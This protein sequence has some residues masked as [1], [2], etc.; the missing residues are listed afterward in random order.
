MHSDN[1]YASLEAKTSLCGQIN[2]TLVDLEQKYQQ[3][4]I[5]KKWERVGHV[6]MD[7]HKKSS[8]SAMAAHEDNNESCFAANLKRKPHITF[9]D[10]AKLQNCNHCGANGHVWPQCK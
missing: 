2:S 1:I 5:A 9:E 10:W 6:G 4:I 8:F 3:L 7:A